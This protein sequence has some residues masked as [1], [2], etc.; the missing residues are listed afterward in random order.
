MPARRPKRPIASARVPLPKPQPRRASR[1]PE[2]V[3]ELFAGLATRRDVLEVVEGILTNPA[4]PHWPRV[5]TECLDRGYG[6]PTQPISADK[7][8]PPFVVFAQM[9]M[10]ASSTEA[11]QLAAK[12]A[13]K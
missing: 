1:D 2:S 8:A 6:K 4:H 10:A 12:R 9:P 3:R 5:W 13:L 7:D 11:W